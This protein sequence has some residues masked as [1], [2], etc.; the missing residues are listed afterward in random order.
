MRELLG[1]G[2]PVALVIAAVGRPDLGDIE[3]LAAL[4]AIDPTA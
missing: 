3:L 4:H 1:T 2:T